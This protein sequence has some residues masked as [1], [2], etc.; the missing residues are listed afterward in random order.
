MIAK[1]PAIK[2]LL[3][4]LRLSWKNKLKKA[5]K[6]RQTSW[7][8]RAREFIG[9]R[10]ATATTQGSYLYTDPRPAPQWKV[11]G[12]A[13]A[14]RETPG[15]RGPVQAAWGGAARGEGRD[16]GGLAGGG[17]R[18]RR[19]H[20]QH[21]GRAGD[22]RTAVGPRLHRQRHAARGV[23]GRQPPPPPRRWRPLWQASG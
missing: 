1:Q 16:G 12:S 13:N 19:V 11:G 4:A 15:L 9:T 18:P 23:G 21:D 2:Q 7:K 8:R 3:D 22:R 10:L 5:G 17:R 20:V 14:G 6:G